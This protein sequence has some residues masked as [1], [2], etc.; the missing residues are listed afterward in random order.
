M[1]ELNEVFDCEYNVI[2][3]RYNLIK[4]LKINTQSRMRVFLYKTNMHTFV[5]CKCKDNKIIFYFS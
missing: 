3:V 2:V 1:L 5:V 4:I